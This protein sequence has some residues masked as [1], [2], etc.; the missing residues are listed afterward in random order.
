MR[1]VSVVMISFSYAQLYQCRYRLKSWIHIRLW[2]QQASKWHERKAK[3][4]R[5]YTRE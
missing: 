5:V 3:E 1:S 2:F 4:F